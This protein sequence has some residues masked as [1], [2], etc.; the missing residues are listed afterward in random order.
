ML[1]SEI[2]RTLTETLVSAF[3]S[4]K[5]NVEKVVLFG[6]QAT[7]EATSDSD[8]DFIIVAPEFRNKSVFEK[9]QLATGIHRQLLKI[10]FEPID[11]LYYSDIDWQENNSLMIRAAKQDGK[12]LYDAKK[13]V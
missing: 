11:L 2:S 3:K 7:G 1:K 6:S 4:R 5:V 8:I 9:A 12:I 10:I 13:T